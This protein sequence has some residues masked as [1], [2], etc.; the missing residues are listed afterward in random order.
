MTYRQLLKNTTEEFFASGIPEP[1]T[2]AWELLSCAFGISKKDYFLI[3]ANEAESRGLIRLKESIRIRKTRK[4]LQQILGH[5]GFMGLDFKVNEHVLCPR[6]D[7]EL[8]VEM[9]LKAVFPGASILDL[10][11]GSGCVLISLMRMSGETAG[12]G[13]DISEDALLVAKE[14]AK[15][16]LVHPSWLRGDLFAP[17]KGKRFDIIVSNP[18]YIP[19]DVISGLMPEVRDYEPRQALDG[20]KDGLNF[21]RRIIEAAPDHLNENGSLFFEIGVDEASAVESLLY[22]R[23]FYDIHTYKD[24]A[25]NDR[26]VCARL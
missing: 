17:V 26:V 14:N 7:T 23:G 22:D 5:T 13:V 18:P 24:Y 21:Y 16:N 11:T 10:C 25:A 15:R 12:T 2:D 20:G 1:E 6:Q 8:L 4:P 3:S 19:S 9:A